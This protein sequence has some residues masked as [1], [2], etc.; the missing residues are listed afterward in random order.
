MNYQVCS[1][2]LR[3]RLAE[4]AP[5]FFEFMQ[6]RKIYRGLTD[7]IFLE[8]TKGDEPLVVTS[9]SETQPFDY[10]KWVPRKDYFVPIVVNRLEIDNLH[11]QKR[12]WK[13]Q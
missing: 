9:H 3:K 1:A 12:R 8:S 10:Y 2:T 5:R 4:N 13:K 11:R 7:V 6:T